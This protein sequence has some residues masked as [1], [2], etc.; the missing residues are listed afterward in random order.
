M[1]I[2]YGYSYIYLQD[3]KFLWSKLSLGELYT[4]DADNAN[5]D[6]TDDNTTRQ[7]EHDCIGS[8]PNEATTTKLPI[9]LYGKLIRP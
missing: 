7:T 5:D 8:L 1:C 6:D 4:D 3:I 2:Y 9:I